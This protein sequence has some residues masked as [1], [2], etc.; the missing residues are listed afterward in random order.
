MSHHDRAG[1]YALAYHQHISS[2]VATAHGHLIAAALAA[3][4]ADAE[5]ARAAVTPTEVGQRMFLSAA[6]GVLRTRDTHEL[7]AAVTA[8][9]ERGIQ[10]R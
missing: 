4:V 6:I 7:A 8:I 10:A 2:G 5:F 9:G 3:Q 1:D